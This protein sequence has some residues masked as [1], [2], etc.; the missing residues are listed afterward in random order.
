MCLFMMPSWRHVYVE[1]QPYQCVSSE[2]FTTTSADWTHRPTPARLKTSSR[3][4]HTLTRTLVSVICVDI[5]WTYI[6]S[7]EIYPNLNIILTL[8]VLRLK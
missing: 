2:P 3:W 6:N 7:L 1:T 5:D 4:A 8:Q